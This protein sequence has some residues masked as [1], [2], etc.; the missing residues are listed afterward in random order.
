MPQTPSYYH[1]LVLLI[2][3]VNRGVGDKLHPFFV[4]E[5]RPF[6][7][8]TLG[9]GTADT[10]LLSYMGL[11]ETEKDILYCIMPYAEALEKIKNIN[12]NLKLCKPGRGIAFCLPINCITNAIAQKYLQGSDQNQ[13]GFVMQQE[14]QN[15]QYDL[16]ITITNQGY[17]DDI[18]D[19]A[20]AAGATGGTMLHARGLGTKYAQKFLGI[21]L[22][23][24][25][26]KDMIWILIK[27]DKRQQIMAEILKKHGPRTKANAISFSLPVTGVAGLCSID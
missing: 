23:A 21:S 10:K 26:E 27:K 1:T 20:R 16:I 11:G 25:P 7:L 5:G 3:I 4:Y 19:V 2:T 14:E 8:L 13:G 17:A 18:M 6:A 12:S 9:K 24:E 15:Y 22:Q